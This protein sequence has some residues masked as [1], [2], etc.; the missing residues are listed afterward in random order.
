MTRHRLAWLAGLMM[1]A[2]VLAI[3]LSGCAPGDIVIEEEV[4]LPV[5]KVTVA[6]ENL[7]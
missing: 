6:K 4:P 2:I 5:P 7:C 3:V 1:P